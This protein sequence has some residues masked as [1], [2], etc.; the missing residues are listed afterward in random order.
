[1]SDIKEQCCMV[2]F[3]KSSRMT[4]LFCNNRNSEQLHSG[5]GE[6]LEGNTR[7]FQRNITLLY[8]E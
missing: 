1:M 8:P 4:K 3:I 7:I 6:G 5:G 2:S